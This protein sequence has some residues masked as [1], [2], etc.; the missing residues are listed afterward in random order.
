MQITVCCAWFLFCV[1]LVYGVWLVGQTV[2]LTPERFR[3]GPSDLMTS[4]VRS[5]CSASHTNPIVTISGQF[6][7]TR[8]IFILWPQLLCKKGGKTRQ[9]SGQFIHTQIHTKKLLKAVWSVCRHVP[10]TPQ[11]TDF[12]H[13]PKLFID[14][15]W[16]I[17]FL[18]NTLWGLYG[19]IVNKPC[20]CKDNHVKSEKSSQVYQRT[21][22]ADNSPRRQ[23]NSLEINQN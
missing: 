5:D 10:N 21:T 3:C 15:H 8:R 17:R 4:S 23:I 18:L 19:N 6:M 13:S 12:A 11:N 7:S 16:S 22:M 2:S 20:L 9:S 1:R 14:L